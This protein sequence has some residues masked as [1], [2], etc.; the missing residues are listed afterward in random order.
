MFYLI[1]K[2]SDTIWVEDIK[3]IRYLR[4][5]DSLKA[6]E[7]GYSAAKNMADSIKSTTGNSALDAYFLN[8]FNPDADTLSEIGR[9][10]CRERV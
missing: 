1:S 10:S 2:S 4:Y 5:L 9:A 3:D 7:T 8:R 6:Y